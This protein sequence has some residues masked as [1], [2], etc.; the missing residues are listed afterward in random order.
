MRVTKNKI[1]KKVGLPPGSLIHIGKKRT[2]KL[3]IELFTYN[4][5]QYEEK[6]LNAIEECLPFSEKSNVNWL[7]VDGI[8]QIDVIEVIGKKF[9][10]HPLLL[11]DI[12]NTE[13]RPKLEDYEDYLF[14]TLKMLNYDNDS[15]EIYYEQVSFVLGKNY[16]ISLQETIGDVFDTIRKR[17]REGK[18]KVRRKKAD[19]LLYLLIDA[20]IDNYFII[21]EQLESNSESLEDKI[22]NNP[23]QEALELIQQLKKNILFLRKSILP[24]REAI[25]NLLKEESKLIERKTIKYFSDTYDN[26]IH[27][28]DTLETHREITANL[29]DVY[30]SGL[31]NKMNAIMRVLTIIT[32]IFIPLTFIVGIYGMNFQYMPELEWEWGYPVICIIMLFLSIIMIFFFKKKKWL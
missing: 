13:H 17:I 6:T 23:N 20:V 2:G 11:E 32:T 9:E 5:Q 24:L 28:I 3:I 14:F 31:S 29:M 26:I 25:G 16:I 7:N 18:G 21:L 19:Y 15:N 30:V 27:I 22:F 12:L 8:H 4:E 1:S 10:L